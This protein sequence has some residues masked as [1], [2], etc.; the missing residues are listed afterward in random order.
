[1]S[2]LAFH[3]EARAEYLTALL[4]LEE[5]REGYGARFEAEIDAALDRVRSFPR[6]GARVEGLPRDIEARAFPR[7]RFRYSLMVVL[8]AE[9][10]VVLAVA[11]QSRRTGYWFERLG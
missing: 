7:R 11:H 8:E 10:P 5:E 6:S 2:A 4:H 1:M 3:P 9:G